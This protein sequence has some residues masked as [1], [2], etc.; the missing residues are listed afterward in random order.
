MAAGGSGSPLAASDA[1]SLAASLQALRDARAA[2]D[3]LETPCAAL[4]T[5]GPAAGKTAL[6]SQVV[7]LALEGS[8]RA[9]GTA[10]V[11]ILVKVQRLQRRLLDAPDAF[12]A[13]WN[14]VDAYLRLEYEASSPAAYRMLR[15]AMMRWGRVGERLGSGSW[16]KET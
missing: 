1:R 12:A 2:G 7:T 13:S 4:L 9:G 10:L 3:A 15:Q 5:A 8:E 16:R 6:L 11:P 14:Y